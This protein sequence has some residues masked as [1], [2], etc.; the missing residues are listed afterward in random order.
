MIIHAGPSEKSPTLQT[1]LQ[2]F[3]MVVCEALVHQGAPCV[4]REGLFELDD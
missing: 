2:G 1:R 3:F 4:L